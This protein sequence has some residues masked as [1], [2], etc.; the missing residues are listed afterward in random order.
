MSYTAQRS[1]LGDLTSVSVGTRAFVDPVLAKASLDASSIMLAMAKVRAD[2]R[3]AVMQRSLERLGV[4]PQ[5]V[6]AEMQRGLVPGANPDQVTFDALRLAIANARLDLGIDHIR[7]NIASRSGWDSLIDTGLGAMSANDRATG[8]VVAQGAQTVGTIAQVVPLY[9]QIVGLVTGIG[10]SV[11]GAALDCGKETRDAAT[12][13]A[14]AQAQLA[15]AQQTAAQTQQSALSASRMN[16][17]R[18]VGAG[19]AILL[20]VLGAAWLVMD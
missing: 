18:T 9:G 13:A 11:A 17:I 8:C 15:A 19:G 1:S 12:A 16:R 3:L 20:A 14:A 4:G 7:Q 10:S 2:E 6:I 5:D